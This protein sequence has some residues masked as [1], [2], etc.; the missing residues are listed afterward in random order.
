GGRSW[1]YRYSLHGKEH[2]IGLGGVSAVPL[3]LARQLAARARQLRATGIDPLTE[4]HE[5]RNTR[6]VEEAKA[7]TFNG[8][9][10]N[11]IIAHEASWKNAKHREQWRSTLKQYVY[12][13]I[14]ALPVQSIDT[15]MV[16]KILQ[17][18]W[19]GKTETASRIRGRIETILDYAKAHKY[20]EGDNPARWRGHLQLM[21]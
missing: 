21:L 18:I 1:L 16:L 7:E 17:P 20:R 13:V 15:A 6:L 9:A 19:R 12:P 3:K 2:R 4:K 10:E 11:Y 8:C 5:R 14:G